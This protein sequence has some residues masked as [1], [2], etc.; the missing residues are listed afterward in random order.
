MMSITS[1]LNV[2][3]PEIII[4]VSAMFILLTD[5]YIKDSSKKIIYALSQLSLL[6]TAIVIARQSFEATQYV[7]NDM[8]VS[9]TL[10]SFL[11]LLSLIS[12][13]IVFI[14]AKS[15]LQKKSLLSGEYF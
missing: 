15:Y 14:Y 9:D 5:L 13:S 12:T 7:F 2:I 6:L 3:L 10:A 1:Q 4:A 11:K 8:Y